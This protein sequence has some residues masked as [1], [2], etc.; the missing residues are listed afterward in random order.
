MKVFLFL[1][2]YTNQGDVAKYSQQSNQDLSI[3]K[4]D[5]LIVESSVIT[6]ENVPLSDQ[7][8]RLNIQ[9]QIHFR[10]GL[11]PWCCV[12]LMFIDI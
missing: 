3:D 8:E 11:Q 7:S 2:K 1:R 12:T 6:H 10:F 4:L 9:I 5:N